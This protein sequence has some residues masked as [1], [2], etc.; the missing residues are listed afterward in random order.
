MFNQHVVTAVNEQVDTPYGG[1]Q[2]I[3]PN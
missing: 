2:Y 3:T 1:N